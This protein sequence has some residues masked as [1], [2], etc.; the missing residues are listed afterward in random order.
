MRMDELKQ[1]IENCDNVTILTHKNPD[2]DTLGCGFALC[3]CLRLMGKNANV[4]NN[5]NF[6]V[7]YSFLYNDYYVQSFEEQ[8]VIAVD[9]A[10]TQ[11][12]GSRLAE[13][14]DKIDLCI[15]HHIS[16][17]NFAKNTYV[18]A[19]ASAACLILFELFSHL[20]VLI[21]DQIAMCLYTGIATDT[22][23]FKF[24][25]TTPQAHMA[26]ATLMTF[27]ID[28]AKINRKMFD[29]KTKARI[30]IEERAMNKMEYYFDDRCSIMI[31]TQET[32]LQSGLE[33]SEFDGLASLALQVEEVQIGITMRERKKGVY[34]ISVRTTEEVN[35]S[36]FCAKFGGG[37][38]IRAAGCEIS[39][40]LDDIKQKI[41]KAAKEVV[42][43]I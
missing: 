27:N 8:T 6:P 24:E 18:D 10:D 16:N 35:A 25:N 1:F 21:D 32:I 34:K 7:R 19:K 9:V 36:E 42:V 4:I 2:G 31:L 43:N 41:L 38:H 26:C 30:K 23:C 13:Y 29:V 20:P 15:D 5:D 39:G 11:L 14:A 17:T 3:R 12:L 40:E 37:G 22:G 28:F 33:Q